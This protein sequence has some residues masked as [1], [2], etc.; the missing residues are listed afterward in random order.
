MA[1]M[2]IMPEATAATGLL[3]LAQRRARQRRQRHIAARQLVARHAL[4]QPALQ[5]LRVQRAAVARHHGGH[6]GLAPARVGHADHGALGHVG[7]GSQRVFNLGGVDVFAARDDHVLGAAHDAPAAVGRHLRQVAAVKPACASTAGTSRPVV[8]HDVGRAQQHLAHTVFRIR[9]P[10]LHAWRR[11]AAGARMRHGVAFVQ[12]N[13]K[14][15]GLGGAIHIAHRQAAGMKGIHQRLGQRAGAGPGRAQ[16]G[17]VRGGPGRV[18][19]HQRLHDGR[20][21]ER[22]RGFV[23]GDALQQGRCIKARVQDDAGP[24]IQRRQGLDAQA[25]HM[26]QRQH[27]GHR[28]SRRDACTW[29]AMAMLARRLPWVC[30]APRGVPVVPE[31]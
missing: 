21:H 30:T 25:A 15:P 4:A 10:R 13:G 20:H 2:A 1:L 8:A 27:G 14:R 11:P 9:Q 28:V 22:E 26:E 7:V 31:V 6:H 16:A 24:G 5:R 19:G 18:L 12:R 29:A 17:Q 23:P 3:H